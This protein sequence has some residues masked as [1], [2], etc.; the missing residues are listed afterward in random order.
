MKSESRRDGKKNR[1]PETI[2]RTVVQ[3]S[4]LCRRGCTLFILQ[5]CR[6]ALD[7]SAVALS[8]RRYI[9]RFESSI[10]PLRFLRSMLSPQPRAA[11]LHFFIFANLPLRAR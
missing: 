10:L 8:F 4:R 11:V 7:S 6:Y 2:L 5:I 1:V 9:Q 3:P